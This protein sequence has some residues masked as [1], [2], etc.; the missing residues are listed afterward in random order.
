VRWAALVA[1]LVTAGAGVFLFALWVRHGGLRQ[2]EGIRPPVLL[3]HGGLAA[4]GLVL[5][6]AYL[7]WD[8]DWLAWTAVAVLPVVAAIGATMFAVTWRGRT[9]VDHTAVPAESSF[10]LPAVVAH[11]I[12]GVTTLVLTVLAAAGIG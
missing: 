8:H 6:I 3:T 7:T 4:A 9:Q 12:L 11:G 2:R 1:W 10:P 5:W